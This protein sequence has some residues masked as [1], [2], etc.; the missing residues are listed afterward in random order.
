MEYRG[1][2][3][4]YVLMVLMVVCTGSSLGPEDKAV[5]CILTSLWLYTRYFLL[6]LLEVTCV[7]VQDCRPKS[8]C[9]MPLPTG[10]GTLGVKSGVGRDVQTPPE[11]AVRYLL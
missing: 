10:R 11:A 8:T 6:L 1:D 4:C 3:K 2:Y 9:D 5:I 7:A